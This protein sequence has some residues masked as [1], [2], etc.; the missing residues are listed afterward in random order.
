MLQIC[1]HINHSHLSTLPAFLKTSPF[2]S[3][4]ENDGLTP[5]SQFELKLC[6]NKLSPWQ[7]GNRARATVRAEEVI[8]EHN[9]ADILLWSGEVIWPF[10]FT[11]ASVSSMQSEWESWGH[12][13]R[14]AVCNLEKRS[15]VRNWIKKLAN[16]CSLS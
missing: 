13:C 6:L 2:L 4:F 3:F 9:E 12:I 5:F 8:K 1:C 16:E 7:T 11:A 15:H 14:P 10:T